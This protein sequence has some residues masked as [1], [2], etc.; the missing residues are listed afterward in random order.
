MKVKELKIRRPESYETSEFGFKGTVTVDGEYGTQE[1][2]L[3][4]AA[5]SRIFA[6]IQQEIGATAQR[7]AGQ[8]GVAMQD[9][10][11]GGFLLQSDGSVKTPSAPEIPF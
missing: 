7:V 5:I 4:P 9:A 10:I 3:S 1:F 2:R 6:Q 11:D 8:V